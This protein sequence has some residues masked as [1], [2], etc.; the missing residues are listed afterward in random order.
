MATVFP[1]VA[2]YQAVKQRFADEGTTA[3]VVFGRRETAKQVNQG[4]GGAN[5]VIFEPGRDG[6]MGSYLPAKYPGRDTRP[7]GCLREYA[8]V[9]CWASAGGTGSNDESAHYEAARLLHDATYRSLYLASFDEVLC[10]LRFGDP[11]WIL[12]K[13]ER[14]YGYECQFT[15]DLEAMIPDAPYSMTSMTG[16]AITT[17]LAESLT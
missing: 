2:L 1:L 14:F 8:T 10:T 3:N 9:Y 15:L 7:L 13:T 11:S 16:A 4:T 5:R 12:A 17:V 6:R